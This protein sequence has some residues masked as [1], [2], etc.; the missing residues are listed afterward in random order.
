M[1]KP[2]TLAQLEV[3]AEKVSENFI[4]G[5][6]KTAWDAIMGLSK[7]QQPFVVG[8]VVVGMVVGMPVNEMAG[9]AGQQFLTWLAAMAEASSSKPSSP[10]PKRKAP[11]SL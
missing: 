4:L 10:S 1:A 3:I 9:D 2:K 6:R 11:N 8:S 7:T 5:K